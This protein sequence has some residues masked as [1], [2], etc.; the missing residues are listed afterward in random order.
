MKRII[1][2]LMA[3]L[4]LAGCSQGAP[5]NTTTTPQNTE[6]ET[7]APAATVDF[8]ATA[9]DMF[10]DRDLNAQ[11]DA[12][13]AVTITLQGN[14]ATASSDSVVI[15]DNY[16]TITEEATYVITGT[17]EGGM[18]LVDTDKQAKP[19]LVL[20]NAH[21]RASTTPALYIRQADKVVVTL[22][23]NTENTLSSGESFTQIDD[24]NLDGAVFSKAD[25]TF[26]GQGSLCVSAPAGHGIVCKD[27]LVLTGGTYTVDAASHGLDAND[28]IRMQDASVTVTAGKDG[29]HAENA[30]DASLGFLFFASGSLTAN[31]QGDGISAG[32]YA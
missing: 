22:A 23:Q 28:S 5:E 18:L 21:I 26:N 15:K 25:L 31:A 30:E 6:P 3:I 12:G 7:T 2:L 9:Q 4:F 14:T 29:L 17:L 27:D 10:T 13:K 32:S 16:I 11:Y 1:C 20:D 8:S 19:Q 24:N